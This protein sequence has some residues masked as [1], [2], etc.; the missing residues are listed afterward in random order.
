MFPHRSAKSISSTH[1]HVFLLAITQ[2]Q[3]KYTNRKLVE[4]MN[5]L[6]RPFRLTADFSYNTANSNLQKFSDDSAIIGLITDG[7]ER[8]Y[9]ELRKR[10]LWTGAS[11]TTSRSAQ[12]KPKNWWWT[13]TGAS[14]HHIY[15]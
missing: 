12:E 1:E 9:R 10:A 6:R 3:R 7:D 8:E 11:G 15:Q 2:H 14:K 4:K 5:A 13:F